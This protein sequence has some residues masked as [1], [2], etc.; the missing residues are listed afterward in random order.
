MSVQLDNINKM[1]LSICCITIVWCSIL[2]VNV[3]LAELSAQNAASGSNSTFYRGFISNSK[4]D[5]PNY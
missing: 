5:R 3:K 1:E 4:L 2:S